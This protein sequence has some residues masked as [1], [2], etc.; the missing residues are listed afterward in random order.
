MK[1]IH[2]LVYRSVMGIAL[3]GGLGITQQVQAAGTGDCTLVGGGTHPFT[4]DF[5]THITDPYDN[6]K[7]NVV[8]DAARGKWAMTGYRVNCT[9]DSSGNM[10][11]SYITAESLLGNTPLTVIDGWNYFPLPNTDGRLAVATKVA[12][13]GGQKN[14]QFYTPFERMSNGWTEFNGSCKNALYDSGGTGTVNLL[15]LKPFVGETNIPPV[16]FLN[17]Y[18]SSHRNFRGTTPVASVSMSGRVTVEQSCQF[19]V[20]S[21]SIPFGSIMSESFK[22][23]PGQKPAGFNKEFTKEITMDCNNISEGVKV[24][25]S[26]KGET[27][28]HINNALKT[29]NTVDGSENKDIAIRFIDN[30]NGS[31]IVKPTPLG[32]EGD[33]TD[34][35]LSVDMKGLGDINS[36]GSASFTAYPISATGKPPKVG[37]FRAIATLNIR[38][39]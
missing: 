9:C 29:V 28:E 27:N 25:L 37:E 19:S 32:Q 22:V 39:D 4:F 3:V 12:I 8:G 38:L 2:S 13:G 18:I 11:E 21:I 26:L 23:S 17:I 20:S 5:S 16:T 10:N 34:G 24:Y 1:K 6:K 15:F 31:S 7:G 36:K 33:S 35:L 30:K 14:Q